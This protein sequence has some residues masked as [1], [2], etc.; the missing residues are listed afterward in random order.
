MRTL[1]LASALLLFCAAVSVAQSP[2]LDSGT[3]AGVISQTNAIG[4]AGIVNSLSAAADAA[5]V[6][7]DPGNLTALADFVIAHKADHMVLVALILMLLLTSI[8]WLMG[9][10]FRLFTGEAGHFAYL[11]L[12]GALVPTIAQLFAH[13]HDGTGVIAVHAVASGVMAAGGLQA[14]AHLVQGFKWIGRFFTSPAAQRGFSTPVTLVLAGVAGLVILLA[15]C[16]TCK[17]PKNAELKQCVLEK[18][19]VDCSVEAGKSVEPRIGQA[20]QKIITSGGA[21]WMADLI[22]LAYQIGA[23][24]IDWI[25]CDAQALDT[26]FAGQV[27]QLPADGPSPPTGV[28]AR[29]KLRATATQVH[30]RMQEFI[31]KYAPQ[32][33]FIGVDSMPLP[34]VAK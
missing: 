16:A 4:D 20:I 34:S 22:E 24:G 3:V 10:G 27:A 12:G 9:H 33:T 8:R 17:A 32:K 25:V 19:I 2:S 21:T 30:D 31:K 7:P 5:A 14:L 1:L 26:Y 6:A 11:F 13:T 23:G 29:L 18:A 28:E 15:A